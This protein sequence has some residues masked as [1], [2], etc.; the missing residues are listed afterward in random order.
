MKH[1]ISLMLLSSSLAINS[2]LPV[3]AIDINN[4]NDITNTEDESL[5]V[6]RDSE[7]SNDEIS[8]IT[9]MSNQELSS[10]STIMLNSYNE[11]YTGSQITPQVIVIPH[12]SDAIF[13]ENVDY[14]VTY[15]ENIE[16]TG[17]I[18]VTGMG[19]YTGSTSIEFNI[20]SGFG[21]VSTIS[22][23]GIMEITDETQEEITPQ[24]QAIDI[25]SVA[26]NVQIDYTNNYTYT[27]GAILPTLTGLEG[28]TLDTD[29]YILYQNN[30]NAGIDTGSVIIAGKGDYNGAILKTFTINP[31]DISTK[32]TITDVD[33][34]HEYTGSTITPIPTVSFTGF[35]NPT[36]DVSYGINTE[37]GN[38]AGSVTITGNGN[39]TG[40]YTTNFNI[41]TKAISDSDIT[42]I[43][44]SYDYT[45]SS[46]EP[47]PTIV[48]DG[49]TLI[50]DTDYSVTYDNNTTVEDG[51]K[52]IIAGINNYTGDFEKSFSITATDL[53]TAVVNGIED[54]YVYT[55]DEI[56]P[57]Q[58]SVVLNNKILEL[59]TDYTI[60]Y[61]ANT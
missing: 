23:Y 20:S 10:I 14:T 43:N 26:T 58:I 2:V 25:S 36:Y 19:S 1:K 52:V 7:S 27:E 40:S 28:L 31:A 48:V 3:Y 21:G 59:D 60:S 47:V 15:G 44:D 11:M 37:S 39:F 16:G 9:D 18:V 61:D 57:S 17:S 41:A 38:S 24:V 34:S 49:R 32:T 50:K 54:S 42:K 5:A 22:T 35:S 53:R 46:I 29:Y 33:S 8:I 12:T 51:G 30:I 6:L 55:G 4:P 13:Q 56:K 45:G